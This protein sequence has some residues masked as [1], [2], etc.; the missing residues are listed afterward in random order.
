MTAKQ[1]LSTSLET[2]TR[3]VSPVIGV[4]VLNLNPGESAPT[5]TP[6]LTYT[7]SGNR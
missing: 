5:T 2:D 4:Y 1:P 7:T 6:E 3:A